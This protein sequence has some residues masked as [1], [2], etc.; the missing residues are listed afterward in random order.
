[1]SKKLSNDTV[2]IFVDIQQK[3]MELICL[4]HRIN[5]QHKCCGTQEIFNECVF[6]NNSSKVFV[7][8][9]EDSIREVERTGL[10]HP[11]NLLA[12]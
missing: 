6:Y 11:N 1:M 10:P 2:Q 12:C 7:S 4:S 9:T 3:F 5:M 8:L